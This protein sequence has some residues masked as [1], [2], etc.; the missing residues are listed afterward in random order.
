MTAREI[1]DEMTDNELSQVY[2]LL[3][4][5]FERKNPFNGLSDDDRANL[6]IKLFG[7]DEED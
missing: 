5:L 3:Y 2:N 6:S 7:S 4:Y 1:F